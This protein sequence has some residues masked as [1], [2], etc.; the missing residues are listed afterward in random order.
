MSSIQTYT[1]A[2]PEAGLKRALGMSR[3]DI[4]HEMNESSLKG[5]GGAGFP[6]GGKWNFAASAKSEKKYIICN[7]DEG[8]PGTFKDR[9]VLQEHAD[10]VFEGMTI[11][12]KAV[13]SR[14]G[15]LFL[16]GE[17]NRPQGAPGGHPA[18]PPGAEAP[19]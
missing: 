17:Y 8:E 7:A 5:R 4:I 1:Q 3:P 19:G 14:E 2:T 12:A 16:R 11:A 10:L 15:I 9:V 13:G 18:A 6:V